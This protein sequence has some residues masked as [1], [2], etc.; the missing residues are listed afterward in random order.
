MTQWTC[1]ADQHVD[2]TN[3]AWRRPPIC[4]PGIRADRLELARMV[5][6]FDA[7][8]LSSAAPV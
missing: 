6:R 5:G 7:A 3:D 2:M 8:D 4:A 1:L